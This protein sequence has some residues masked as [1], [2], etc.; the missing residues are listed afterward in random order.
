MQQ[1]TLAEIGGNPNPELF[2]QALEHFKASL[3]AADEVLANY[4]EL[5]SMLEQNPTLPVYDERMEELL[6]ERVPFE[7]ISPDAKLSEGDGNNKFVQFAITS[8][9]LMGVTFVFAGRKKPSHSKWF[10]LSVFLIIS[11]GSCNNVQEDPRTEITS[12]PKILQAQREDFKYLR[13]QTANVIA[14]FDEV[15]PIAEEGRFVITML[16]E[17]ISFPTVYD[18]LIR[19]RAIFTNFYT[20]SCLVSVDATMDVYPA[21]FEFLDQ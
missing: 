5:I 16:P 1:G 3:V 15:L 19:D 6:R 8:I 17:E 20:Q 14:G 11:L 18:S 9:G 21:G 4:D 10:L 12:L 7:R 13:D 2:T